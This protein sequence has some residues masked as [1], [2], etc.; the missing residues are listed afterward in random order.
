[1]GYTLRVGRAMKTV[2]CAQCAAPF[3]IRMSRNGRFCSP[4][5]W[6]LANRKDKGPD[7]RPRRLMAM[8]PGHPLAGSRGLV[9]KYRMI[10]YDAIGPGPHPCRWCGRLLEWR[11]GL[12][13]DAIVRDDELFITN[14]KGRV[15]CVENVCLECG[16]PCRVSIAAARAGQGRFCSRA[17][18]ARFNMRARLE[19]ARNRNADGS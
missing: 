16:A 18:G 10:V 17:C 8:R 11:Y 9:L 14:S 5:C 7:R 19:A 13:P 1:M 3:Q 6:G 4:A 12:V 15:R 2:V